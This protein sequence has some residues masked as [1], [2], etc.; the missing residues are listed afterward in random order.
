[1][2]SRWYYLDEFALGGCVS[3]STWPV[4]FK[5][6]CVNECTRK[7]IE[8]NTNTFC[9]NFILSET[10]PCPNLNQYVYIIIICESL[11][12]CAC[13]S[14]RTVPWI[15]SPA[16]VRRFVWPEG[17]A[18]KDSTTVE[19][20]LTYTKFTCRLQELERSIN[21][22]FRHLFACKILWRP[23][24]CK[25]RRQK[26]YQS[27]SF[28]FF[29][30]TAK[31]LGRIFVQP[32]MPGPSAVVRNL[33]S[34][35]WSDTLR[36]IREAIEPHHDIGVEWFNLQRFVISQKKPLVRDSTAGMIDITRYQK[37]NWSPLLCLEVAAFL[38]FTWLVPTTAFGQLHHLLVY[39]FWI[40]TWWN[41][42]AVRFGREELNLCFCWY[43]PSSIKKKS[44]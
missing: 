3:N 25:L 18:W 8:Y 32:W 22:L 2:I 1:M 42:T 43:L 29:D 7:T 20:S 44:W 33:K 11:S 34:A 39:H 9:K 31:R 15:I 28:F 6:K 23:V 4:L 30:L 5:K 27:C 21:S 26:R 10:L 37:F 41:S 14:I 12:L 24:I 40:Y 17:R 36:I 38:L 13:V 16:Q 19:C 35:S